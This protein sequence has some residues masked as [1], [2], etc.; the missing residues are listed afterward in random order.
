LDPVRHP[1]DD[2]FV[3]LR[4]KQRISRFSSSST[5]LSTA[6]RSLF[7]YSIL[8]PLRFSFLCSEFVSTSFRSPAPARPF[9]STSSLLYSVYSRFFLRYFC[10]RDPASVFSEAHESITRYLQTFS[11]TL[12]SSTVSLFFLLLFVTGTPRSPLARLAKL[13]AHFL[14]SPMILWL[15]RFLALRH[16]EFMETSSRI[17]CAVLVM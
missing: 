5:F 13:L 14:C 11:T 10:Q 15:P 6:L 8:L 3:L 7:V 4:F 16:L 1:S 12:P 9:Y 2:T 17:G